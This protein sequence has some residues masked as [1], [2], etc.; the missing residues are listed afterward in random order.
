MA[1]QIA[2]RYRPSQQM[3]VNADGSIDTNLLSDSVVVSSS[4]PLPVQLTDGTNEA[5]IDSLGQ[6]SVISYTSEGVE[7]YGSV[8]VSDVARGKITG[9][10]AI[11]KF[12]EN[13]DVDVGTEDIWSGGGTW[14]PPTQ[15]RR[16]Q[17]TSTS[18]SDNG[19]GGTTGALTV[20]VTGIASDGTRNSETIT[21]N[22]TSNVLTT[23]SYTM[24]DRM[25]V[26]T[27]GSTGSNIG[28]ITATAQTDSTVTARI[29]ATQNQTRMAI[30]QVP[31]NAQATLYSYYIII[32]GSTPATTLMTIEIQEKKNVANSPWVTKHIE[33]FNS[34]IVNEATHSFNHY[35]KFSAGSYIKMVATSNKADSSIGAGFNLLVVND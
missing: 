6:L 31:T 34:D 19:S 22:G 2:D 29:E 13:T 30:F 32:N 16:H 26:L 5:S 15:A 28:T 12:G 4:A 1:E 17:I 27:V 35:K 10:Q 23:N 9:Y 21:L 33:T 18:T 14:V 25:E 11:D 20:V 8:F 24:I 7:Q 3:K